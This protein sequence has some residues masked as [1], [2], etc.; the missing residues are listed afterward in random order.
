MDFLL[1]LSL[2]FSLVLPRFPLLLSLE[3]SGS[4]LVASGLDEYSLGV[5]SP[6]DGDLSSRLRDLGVRS[7][8]FLLP[9]SDDDDE[10]VGLPLL[11]LPGFR[12]VS[13]IFCLA[14]VL[15]PR[16]RV[17]VGAGADPVSSSVPL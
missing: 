13:V 17:S 10:D 6:S 14:A 8:W 5:D 15:V 9:L 16:A 2:L 12:R 3:S 7:R 11:G 4:E 1:F